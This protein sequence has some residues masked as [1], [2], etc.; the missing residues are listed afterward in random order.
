VRPVGATHAVPISA[1]VLAATNR[2]LIAMVAQGLFR[3]DLYF[4]L[5]VVNLKIPPLRE[6]REDIRGAGRV[7]PGAGAARDRR[8]AHASPRTRCA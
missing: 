2:D 1:R 5:N 3:K 4:R 7:L 8:T 6:R